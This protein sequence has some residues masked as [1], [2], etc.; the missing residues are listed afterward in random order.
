MSCMLI[1]AGKADEEYYDL[2]LV[3]EA[4]GAE[5]KNTLTPVYYEKT[6][7]KNAQTE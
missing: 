1:P 7:G 3:I 5:S 4:L 6:K 2:G